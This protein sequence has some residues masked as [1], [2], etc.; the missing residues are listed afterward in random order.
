MSFPPESDLM[1]FFFFHIEVLHVLFGIFVKVLFFPVKTLFCVQEFVS[2]FSMIFEIRLFH[3]DLAWLWP[4]PFE[5]K[6]Y[7]IGNVPFQP[8]AH[9]FG[10]VAVLL[11][12]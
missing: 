11:K 4:V 5:I 10:T 3:L 2:H 1:P 9:S 8:S 12:L 6:G 7:L